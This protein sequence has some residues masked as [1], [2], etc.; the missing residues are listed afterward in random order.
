MLKSTSNGETLTHSINDPSQT[1]FTY[2]D[3]YLP[4]DRAVGEAPY[5]VTISLW[6]KFHESNTLDI[7]IE[8]LQ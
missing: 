1:F 7:I 4:E 2:Q 8:V 3:Y 6:Q 5:E